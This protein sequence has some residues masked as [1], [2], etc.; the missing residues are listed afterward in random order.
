MIS[1]MTH[2]FC[3]TELTGS[4]VESGQIQKEKTFANDP[5]LIGVNHLNKWRSTHELTFDRS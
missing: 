5:T 3:I 4:N 1:N 2:P